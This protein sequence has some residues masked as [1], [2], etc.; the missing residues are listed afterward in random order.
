MEVGAFYL[1]LSDHLALSVD[2]GGT[3]AASLARKPY[4]RKVCTVPLSAFTVPPLVVGGAPQQFD[5][6]HRNM[7]THC[8][9]DWEPHLLLVQTLAQQLALEDLFAVH[10][11]TIATIL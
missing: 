1:R 10:L 9:V 7:Q 3:A 4:F 11:L 6:Y 8:L 2:Q 5:I